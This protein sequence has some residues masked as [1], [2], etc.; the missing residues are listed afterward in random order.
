MNLPSEGRALWQASCP[1]AGSDW[2]DYHQLDLPGQLSYPTQPPHFPPQLSCSFWF[3]P[4][5]LK[6]GETQ[7]KDVEAR[8]WWKWSAWSTSVWGWPAPAEMVSGVHQAGSLG[9]FVMLLFTQLLSPLLESQLC[10]CLFIVLCLFFWSMT[11]P[12]LLSELG[13]AEFHC[14]YIFSPLHAAMQMWNTF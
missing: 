13:T 1:D 5:R 14:W 10:L 8:Q 4:R 6:S 11:E 9:Y 2:P 7:A 12:H 3:P